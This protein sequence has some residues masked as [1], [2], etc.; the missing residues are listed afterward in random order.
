MED[1]FSTLASPLNSSLP[2]WRQKYRQPPFNMAIP[3]LYA[4]AKTRASNALSSMREAAPAVQAAA[5]KRDWMDFR[6]QRQAAK[7]TGPFA[8]PIPAW[9]GPMGGGESISTQEQADIARHNNEMARL[10]NNIRVFRDN[11]NQFRT[12]NL[13]KPGYRSVDPDKPW[14]Y[15]QDELFDYAKANMPQDQF[16][17][18]YG[19]GPQMQRMLTERMTRAPE[20]TAEELVFDKMR[21]AD[22][23]ARLSGTY[24]ETSSLGG[25]PFQSFPAWEQAK[26]DARD[27]AMR[28]EEYKPVGPWSGPSQD[29]LDWRE[30]Q[31]ALAAKHP[32]LPHI[33]LPQAA[34]DQKMIDDPEYAQ[35]V[36]KARARNNALLSPRAATPEFRRIAGISRG[37]GMPF[38]RVA[39][40]EAGENVT[41]W[42]LAEAYPST[43]RDR[44]G[45]VTTSYDVAKYHPDT[46]QAMES[47][48]Q[49]N[50]VGES[51]NP[52]VQ[53]AIINARPQGNQSPFES[54][55]DAESQGGS[56]PIRWADTLR[57]AGWSVKQIE[58]E[59]KVRWGK[60]WNKRNWGWLKRAIDSSV[61][62]PKNRA[63]NVPLNGIGIY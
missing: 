13:N 53:K 38:E 56:D 62:D 59:G 25:G 2:T 48:A 52:E 55:R 12:P 40:A 44:F 30:R 50:A 6:K 51:D 29:T 60:E 20:P 7:I 47:A 16:M 21:A 9:S 17:R 1:L 19:N 43:T 5:T 49:W 4:A 54:L 63:P 37:T 11:A 45:N 28:G 35:S 32:N 15:G 23:E 36:K 46:L 26:L 41:P 3:G 22:R 57:K 58:T 10:H 27:S 34:L 39:A 14:Q 33:A 8:S 18:E 42:Q 61:V 24:P 31:M